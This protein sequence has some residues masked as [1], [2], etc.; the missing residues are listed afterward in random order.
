MYF[1]FLIL[2]VVRLGVAVFVCSLFFW[3]LGVFRWGFGCVQFNC[4][5]IGG[6]SFVFIC[7]CAV[8]SWVLGVV[9]WGLAM[10]VYNFFLVS[11][12]VRWDLVLSVYNF[13]FLVL[14]VARS[15]TIPKK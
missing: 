9:R 13:I 8:F 15:N 3:I 2:G 4:L 14:G 1:Y 10:F 12:V 5:G 6:Y 7:M 11:C